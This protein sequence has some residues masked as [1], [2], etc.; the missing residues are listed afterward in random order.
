MFSDGAFHLPVDQAFPLEDAARAQAISQ[1]GHVAGRLV[2]TV[3]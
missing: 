2:I 3:S 1:A